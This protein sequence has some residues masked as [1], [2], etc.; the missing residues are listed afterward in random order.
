MTN[1][2]D[3]VYSRKGLEQ[4]LL[5]QFQ[6]GELSRLDRRYIRKMAE[7]VSRAYQM[8]L[9]DG[10]RGVPRQDAPPPEGSDMVAVVCAAARQAYDTGY[11]IGALQQGGPVPDGPHRRE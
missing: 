6:K 3:W 1:G 7:N 10:R 5:R 2:L 9:R 11:G 8:G 4:I